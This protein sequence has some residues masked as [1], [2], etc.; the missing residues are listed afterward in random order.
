MLSAVPAIR[1]AVISFTVLSVC[2]CYDL[3]LVISVGCYHFG[4]LSVVATPRRAHLVTRVLVL[5][6][7]SGA[8]LC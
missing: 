6:W 7:F 4:M 1:L 5:V 2:T 3:S 8:V